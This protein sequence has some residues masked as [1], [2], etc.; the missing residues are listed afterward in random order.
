MH[1]QE[2]KH[3]LF[4]RDQ[5]KWIL[6][7]LLFST[8][9]GTSQ[10][11]SVSILIPFVAFTAITFT[12]IAFTVALATIALTTI[13]FTTISVFAVELLSSVLSRVRHLCVCVCVCDD[14]PTTGLL[15][16][17]RTQEGEN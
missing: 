3:R 1:A 13:A 7:K 4:G 2:V 6:D 8:K 11:Q 12:T 5:S 10:R 17:N 9:R 14:L 15:T 16:N